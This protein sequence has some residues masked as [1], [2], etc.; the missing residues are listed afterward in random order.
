MSRG[1]MIANLNGFAKRWRENIDSWDNVQRGHSESSSAQTFWSDLL[2]QFGVI[3]ER[4]TIF[5]ADARRASTGNTGS[6][7]VFWSSVFLGEAKS[8]GKDLDAAYHQALDYL[9]GGSVKQHEWPK[10]I[11]VTDFERIR[12][13]RLGDQPWTA[14][15]GI[16]DIA[17][18]VDQLTFLA[19]HETVSKKEEAD[20]SIEAA[21]IMAQ[22]YEAMTGIDA[23]APV[24]DDAATDAD[25]EDDAIEQASIFLTRLLFLLYGDD[26][27][28]WRD[29][30]FYD[31]VLNYTQDDGADLGPKLH[32]LFDTL[33]TPANK[34]SPRLGNMLAQFP[35]VNGSLF[36]ADNRVEYFDAAMR[37]A[38]LDACRFRWTRISPAVFGSMFQL[39]KSKEARRAA[40]EHYTSETNILKTIGPLF[41][42]DLRGEADRLIR[43]KSTR[44]SEL[45]AFRDQLATHLFIDPACGCGNFLVVAYRELRRIETDIIVEIRHREGQAGASLDATLETKLTIGQFHGIELNWWPAKIAET[46]MFLVD[47]QANRELAKAIGQA[48]ER[49]PITITAHIHHTNAL[50]ADWNELIPAAAGATYVFGNPPFIGQYTKTAEQTADM[51]KVWGTDY[52]GYLDFVT[53]WHAQALHLYADGRP[54][55]FGYVTTNSITQGQPVPALFGP[56]QREGWRIKYAHRTFAWD[57]E[58]PGK[59]AVHC[60]IVGFTRDRG[61]QQRLWDYPVVNGDPVRQ[62][63]STGINAYLVDG[64]WVLVAKRLSPLSTEI[65]RARFGS[66]PVGTALIIEPSEKP[67][68]NADPVARKY[69]RPFRMGMELVNGLDRWCLWMATDDFDPADL[70]RSK[71]LNTRVASVRAMRESSAK[72][73]TQESA[74]TSHLFQE[75]H[76]PNT[77]YVGIPA[78]VSQTR[79][80]YTV[81]H[82]SSDVIAGNKV[83]TI[84]D[85]DGLQFAFLSSAMLITWQRAVGGRLKSDLS[86]SNTVV[87]NTFPVPELTDD[88]RQRIVKAGQ[89]V[90][91]ARDQHP[92]RSL[93]DHYNPL[94]MDPALVKAHDALDRVVD[95]AFG[96]PRKLT[97]ER[98]RLELLF[99]NYQD[100][101]RD[102]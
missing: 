72:R 8:V 58:A 45:K 36:T 56:I 84:P 20:A 27:G 82:L 12:I 50:Q 77:D 53:G 100:L 65:A 3:P 34:R 31:Y 18:H 9:A 41:L 81:A 88:I 42:D 7:D 23:D 47:Q 62:Q 37:E 61:A 10:Y 89:G 15:F 67:E 40:G 96:A 98:Q 44:V 74:A 57:S 39:V 28:L 55:E 22:L 14:E 93:A 4:M 83:Y 101:T 97:G 16:D 48:P 60:V 30:L 33:N 102:S 63:V 32:A 59:A 85:P 90:L 64:P 17:E 69:V 51:R 79:P 21:R 70:R 87:W 24:A 66:K 2:R 73:A 80:Y 35:Y 13:D 68:V 71:V 95:R 1:T 94:A 29:D 6:M 49:L 19:G 75:N 78:V 92:G 54:G 76:Q 38:L 11:V 25:D 26:A 99:Q 43:N 91:D 86:F 5:E 52:D 46:A